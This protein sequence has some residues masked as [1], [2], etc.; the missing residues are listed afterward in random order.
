MEIIVIVGGGVLLS[1]VFIYAAWREVLCVMRNPFP[2]FHNSDKRFEKI[3]KEK[4]RSIIED[5]K[6]HS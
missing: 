4:T 6:Q 5:M 1:M 3:E 2:L